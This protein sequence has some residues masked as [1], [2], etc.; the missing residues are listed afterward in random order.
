MLTMGWANCGEDDL[1]RPIGY[2]HAATCDHPD[3]EAKIDRGLVYVCG[4]MHGGD[5]I[6]CGRYFCHRH[7]VVGCVPVQLCEPCA[8]RYDEADN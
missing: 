1:G 4:G 2:A 8:A 6:G 3:C 5:G 7:L